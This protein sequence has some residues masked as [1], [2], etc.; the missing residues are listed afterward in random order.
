M[1]PSTRWVA[2]APDF[3]PSPAARVLDTSRRVCFQ[4]PPYHRLSP[5]LAVMLHNGKI[6][7]SDPRQTAWAKRLCSKLRTLKEAVDAMPHPPP[8]VAFAINPH[9]NCHLPESWP[10]GTA[11]TTLAYGIGPKECRTTAALPWIPNYH[12]TW[13]RDSAPPNSTRRFQKLERLYPWHTKRPTA[14]WRGSPTD[15]SQLP[16]RAGGM[17]DRMISTLPAAWKA[18]IAARARA[19]LLSM[20]FP[21]QLDLK[22]AATVRL[23]LSHV[24]SSS[25]SAPSEP[26]TLVI[27]GGKHHVL[28][29]EAQFRHKYIIDIA[30]NGYSARPTSLL[31]G[32]SLVILQRRYRYWWSRTFDNVTVS[33]DPSLDTLAAVVRQLQAIDGDVQRRVQGMQ[34]LVA[35]GA[36]SPAA[37]LHQ[38]HMLFQWLAEGGA[39]APDEQRPPSHMRPLAEWLAAG[40]CTRTGWRQRNANSDCALFLDAS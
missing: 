19:V 31:L 34:D 2:A 23:N 17:S 5:V 18:G 37:L 4:G 30:G 21:E 36:L 8:N 29:F 16:Y 12:S 27:T 33:V 13:W 3:S 9:D 39:A 40:V 6:Y 35:G 38:W 14:V 22:F 11:I 24:P 28:P 26:S 1:H 15:G 25:E 7:T 32:N 20:I 10:K